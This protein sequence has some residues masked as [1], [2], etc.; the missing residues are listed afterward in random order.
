M[1]YLFQ[2]S[3]EI[4][5]DEPVLDA[6]QRPR[7]A[8]IWK[9]VASAVVIIIATLLSANVAVSSS[10][11][12][13]PLPDGRLVLFVVQQGKVLICWKQTAAPDSPWTDLVGFH[14]NPEGTISDV[15]VGRLPDG[16]LE[17]FATTPNGLLTSWKETPDPNSAWTPWVPFGGKM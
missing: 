10:M 5:K 3:G 13:A 14:P 7:S 15:T 6:S 4:I 11:A 17:L 16:R 2:L 1:Q 8:K 9:Q 12:V